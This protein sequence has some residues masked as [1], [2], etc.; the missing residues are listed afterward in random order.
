MMVDVVGFSWHL[1][2]CE[3]TRRYASQ[4]DLQVVWFSDSSTLPH[5]D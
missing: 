3:A 5:L 2:S 4:K 1:E